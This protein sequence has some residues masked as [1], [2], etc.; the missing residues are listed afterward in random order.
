M[1][2]LRRQWALAATAKSDGCACVEVADGPSAVPPV[3][4]SERAAGPDPAAGSCG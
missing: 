2:H 3:R 4:D 1:V